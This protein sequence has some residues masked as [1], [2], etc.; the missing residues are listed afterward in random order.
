VNGKFSGHSVVAY[1]VQDTGT[2]NYDTYVYNPNTPYNSGVSGQSAPATNNRV[3]NQ[4]KSV[5]HI[6]ANGSW[7]F[8]ETGY[9]GTLST[10]NLYLLPADNLP[11]SY[12]LPGSFSFGNILASAPSANWGSPRRPDTRPYAAC[13]SFNRSSNSSG[14][15]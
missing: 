5:I 9:T 10:G 4:Q 6:Q 8:P 13:W 3:A 7:S 12:D 15:K 1:D 2:G 14:V 11:T